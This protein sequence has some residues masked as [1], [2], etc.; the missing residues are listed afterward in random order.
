V[1]LVSSAG[2]LTL[3]N[4]L[5]Y[6]NLS[7]TSGP[8]PNTGFAGLEVEFT[9]E[10]FSKP[11][12]FGVTVGGFAA[13]ITAVDGLA[14]TAT[15]ILPAGPPDSVAL[16][17]LVSSANGSQLLPDA[18]SYLPLVVAAVSPDSGKQTSGVFI[19]NPSLPYQGEPAAE[20]QITALLAGGNLPPDP[21]VSFGNDT[22]GFRTAAVKSVVGDV[23]TVFLPAFLLGDETDVD[24]R[25]TA[26]GETGNLANG[27]TYL[28]SDFRELG[29]YAQA[30][31]G[32]E[33]HKA[34]MAGEFEPDGE[35]LL[36]MGV[37]PPQMQLAVMCFGFG[38]EDPPVPL[39]GGPFG[40]DLA[41]PFYVFF[42]PFPG[43]PAASV[44][45]KMPAF[46]DPA[47]DGVP[48]YL[49]VVTREASGPVSQW[50]F[51]NVLEMTVRA[52]P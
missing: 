28:A 20:I 19:A 31:F 14:G 45:Q 38:L 15:A 23:I 12:D 37:W 18:M 32:T 33:P 36:L 26:G 40:I 25:V 30:G 7:V 49:Q 11:G 51:S 24:V 5:Q 48:L 39:K 16:D 9:G 6:Q 52:S 10:A 22:V 29:D 42:F 34:M 8:V 35:V 43:L 4:V 27:F 13:Q 46:I 41:Q 47:A 17:V 2:K 1:Q 50:G 44:Y 21:V 3:K